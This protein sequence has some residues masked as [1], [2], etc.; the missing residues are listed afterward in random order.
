MTVTTYPTWADWIRYGSVAPHILTFKT[1]G[2]KIDMV[3]A[4]RPRGDLSRMA[5]PSMVL[6]QDLAGGTRVRGDFGGVR[7]DARSTK[8]SF[9]LAPPNVAY[10]LLVDTDHH[11]RALAFPVAQWQAVVEGAADGGFSLDDPRLYGGL[12]RSPAIHLALQHLWALCDEEGAP[13][14]LMAQAGGCEVLAELCRL[15]GAPFAPARGGLAPW[16]ERRCVELMRARLSEDLS[17]DELAA[18][19]RLSPFHFARMFKQS[20]GVPPRAYLTRLRLEKA[21][22]LLEQTDMPV[23]EIALEVGYSSNQVLAR[24]FLKHRHMSPLDHRRARRDPTRPQA[25]R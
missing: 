23:T 14:R 22:E 7:F 5:L 13:S 15:A 19:A 18:E 10:D 20:F 2:T 3:E 25:P 1:A 24:V 11:T 9:Y 21:C 12:F 4:I 6:N 8:G 17:L 16:A